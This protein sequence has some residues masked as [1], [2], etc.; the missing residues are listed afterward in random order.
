MLLGPLAIAAS[1]AA[2]PHAS[3]PVVEGSYVSVTPFRIVDTRTGATDP[4]TYAGQ[5]L[6]TATSL[7]VQVTGVGTVPVPATASTAVLNVT[8]TNP[9]D[10]GFLT[11]FPEGE[12][13]MPTVSNLNFSS[14]ET[15]AN[16]VTVP[17]SATGGVTI[18]NSAGSTDVVAD[19]EGY[20]T[21]T[22]ST[23]GS[24]LYNAISPVRV[25]GALSFGAPVAANTSVPVTVTG[26]LTGVPATA[27]AVVANVTAE[28]ATLPSFLTVYPAGATMPVASNLNFP[29]QAKN[30]AIANRVKIGNL[31][32]KRHRPPRPHGLRPR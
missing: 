18:Y 30:V 22:P 3:P 4:A 31:R 20:Y 29:A 24:G 11:V 13:P 25:L 28:G 8:V 2:V 27:T 10:A 32:D 26:T 7:N 16:L 21:S 5:T 15:V 6:A 12:T 1:A 9:T 19:V 23:N 17:L 14:G